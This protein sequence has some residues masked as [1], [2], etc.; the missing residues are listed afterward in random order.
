MT[1]TIPQSAGKDM[2]SFWNVQI[3]EKARRGYG[4]DSEKSPG[5]LGRV[6]NI[7]TKLEGK[8]RPK[9]AIFSLMLSSDFYES[10]TKRGGS[11]RREAGTRLYPAGRTSANLRRAGRSRVTSAKERDREPNGKR[12]RRSRAQ[13]QTRRIK[14]RPATGEKRRA[15]HGRAGQGATQE[16]R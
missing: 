9:D 16:D 2:W 14:P 5:Y 8:E 11:E 1:G 15:A 3:S 10:L 13:A 7:F 4:G 12:A 6:R